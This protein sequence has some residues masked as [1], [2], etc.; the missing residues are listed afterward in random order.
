MGRMTI[1]RRIVWAPILAVL[2]GCSAHR[3]PA[4][5]VME[6]VER[7][8]AQALEEALAGGADANQKNGRGLTPLIVAARN[9]SVGEVQ[10]LLRHRAHPDLRG[11]VNDWTPLMHAIHKDQ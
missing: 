10:V 11:G 7:G 5:A 9:G 1:L 8:D 2:A 3:V 6:A 4:S